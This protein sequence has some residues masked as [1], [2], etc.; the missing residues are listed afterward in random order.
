MLA[1]FGLLGARK[2]GFD[3]FTIFFGNFF[4]LRLRFL[5]LLVSCGAFGVFF[6]LALVFNRGKSEIFG[7]LDELRVLSSL[8]LLL[9]RLLLEHGLLGLFTLGGGGADDLI[10]G[11]FN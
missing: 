2:V 11:E 9:S 6:R 5:G 10:S 1:L 3:I 7:C 4:G 8:N